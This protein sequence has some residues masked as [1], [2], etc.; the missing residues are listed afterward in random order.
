MTIFERELMKPNLTTLAPNSNY[1]HVPISIFLRRSIE[2]LS[3]LNVVSMSN[4]LKP[5]H[6]E[7][8]VS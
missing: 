7:S 2:N 1:P 4:I 6:F 8:V 5:G 3:F